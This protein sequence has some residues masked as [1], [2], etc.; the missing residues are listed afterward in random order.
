MI[1]SLSGDITIIASWKFDK[2]TSL[3]LTYFIDFLVGLY[4]NYKID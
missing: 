4:S 2:K 3:Y 1:G